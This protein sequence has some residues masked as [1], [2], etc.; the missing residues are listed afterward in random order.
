MR[1]YMT[2]LLV[3]L[4]GIAIGFVAINGRKQSFEMLFGPGDMGPVDITSLTRSKT[5][6]DALACPSGWCVA[7]S[8]F[9]PP[10]Y[11][12]R[13]GAL[14]QRFA[15]SLAQEE[16]L[17]LVGNTDGGLRLRFVQHTPLV[18]FPDTIQ[19]DFL[20]LG[21]NRSTLAIYSRSKYG[22][23]DMGTNRAR[24]ERWLS[25]LQSYEETTGLAT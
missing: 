14:S 8:D 20:S 18:E 23:S 5:G 3:F 11:S 13:V 17:E 19:V 21:E 10:V 15:E 6:N 9:E 24:I 16:K 1:R 22:Y 2:T 4:L 25:R 7:K 12:L